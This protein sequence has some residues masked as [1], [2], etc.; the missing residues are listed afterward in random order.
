MKTIEINTDILETVVDCESYE[1]INRLDK[2]KELIIT[3]KTLEEA[4][5]LCHT[6]RERSILHNA[7]S[8][9]EEVDALPLEDRIYI[10]SSNYVSVLVDTGW[11]KEKQVVAIVVFI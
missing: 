10:E 11:V 8:V 4:V 1:V 9:S 2:Y 6:L 5:D 7:I 3:V